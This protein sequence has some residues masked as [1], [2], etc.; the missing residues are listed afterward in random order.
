MENRPSQPATAGQPSGAPITTIVR[1]DESNP[2]PSCHKYQRQPSGIAINASSDATLEQKHAILLLDPLDQG[3]ALLFV[4]LA[5]SSPRLF[6]QSF[7]DGFLSSAQVVAVDILK[8]VS[9]LHVQDLLTEV[10]RSGN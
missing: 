6:Q 3:E 2:T 8:D 4:D 5:L 7:D 9:P 10:R 1:L